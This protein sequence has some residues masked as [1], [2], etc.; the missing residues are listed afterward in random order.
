MFQFRGICSR[1][2]RCCIAHAA[3]TFEG[4]VPTLPLHRCW[5]CYRAVGHSALV[6]CLQSALKIVA[7]WILDVLVPQLAAVEKQKQ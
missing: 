7:V 2:H 5:R 1:L 6:E 3:A 4:F